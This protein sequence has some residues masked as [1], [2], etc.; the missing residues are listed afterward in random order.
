MTGVA[1]LDAWAAA[2]R[3]PRR[4]RGGRRAPLETYLPCLNAG[5]VLVLALTGS[6]TGS[7]SG[8][9]IL[10]GVVYAIVLL[11]KVVMGGV[12]PERE[13]SALKYGYR[14]A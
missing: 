11:A 1:P 4:P 9:G 14:G 8:S 10:P 2:S 6:A 12:D 5:L 13:L 7:G 3:Q